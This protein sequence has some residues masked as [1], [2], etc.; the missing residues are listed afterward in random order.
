[1]KITADSYTFNFDYWKN[2]LFAHLLWAIEI[3][4]N[5]SNI[6]HRTQ[7]VVIGYRNSWTLIGVK[8]NKEMLIAP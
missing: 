1:M 3:I 4:H 5:C 7:N 8:I 2:T 6:N